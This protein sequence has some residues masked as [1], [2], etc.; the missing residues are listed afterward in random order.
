MAGPGEA[1]CVGLLLLLFLVLLGSASAGRRQ[2][3]V[4]ALVSVGP[5]SRTLSWPLT[6]FG[7]G[8]EILGP[9]DLTAP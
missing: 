6:A 7:M 9:T 3:P 1:L 8:A 2:V 4:Q 5:Q